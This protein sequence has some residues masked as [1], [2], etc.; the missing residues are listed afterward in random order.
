MTEYSLDCRIRKLSSKTIDN[1]MKQLRCFHTHLEEM[2]GI[3][4][5]EEIKRTHIKRFLNMMDEK[6]QKP[7]DIN[8]L[9]KVFQTFFH[10]WAGNPPL[11]ERLSGTRP[12][13][14]AQQNH[15]GAVL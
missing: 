8:D 7:Q 10:F 4:H 11:S 13:E 6:K 15:A 9:V 12:S 14:H 3:I 1:Y 2:Y 5:V